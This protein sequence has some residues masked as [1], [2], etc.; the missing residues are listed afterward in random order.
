MLKFQY[1]IN[2]II[3][4]ILLTVSN[5]R[6]KYYKNLNAFQVEIESHSLF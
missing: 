1:I 2:N 3:K 5:I 4:E 6:K